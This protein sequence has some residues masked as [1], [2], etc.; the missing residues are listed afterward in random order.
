M[1]RDF[2]KNP[3]FF[4]VLI[5]V[6]AAAWPLLVWGRYL[7]AAQK[8]LARWKGW[9][10]DVNAL[11]VEILRLEPDRLI[12]GAPQ[13]KEQFDYLTAISRAATKSG[14][15]SG[16]YPHTTGMMARS[17]KG[18]QTQTATVTLKG[19]DI[20]QACKFLSTIQL[21]WPHLECT[22]IKLLQDK[23]TLD[24]WTVTMGL[25]YFYN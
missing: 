10:P 9:F 19:V 20:V 23:G 15:P 25:E 17:S 7:P 21:D 6:V 4:Y 5:P 2:F 16:S 12:E 18:Q 3:V 24:R 14:I 22:S 1:S 13:V 8:N 11:A